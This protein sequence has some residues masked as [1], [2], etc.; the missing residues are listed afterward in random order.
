MET[1]WSS[2]G[3]RTNTQQSGPI[4]QD[5]DVSTLAPDRLGDILDA[6][7]RVI[8]R[9]GLD[10]LRAQAL[11]D[12]S[13]ASVAT[14]YHYVG[15]LD[16][17]VGALCA[18]ELGL[19]QVRRDVAQQTARGEIDDRL[20]AILAADLD[21]VVWRTRL[22]FLRRAIFDARVRD[23]VRAGEETAAAQLAR[24]VPERADDALRL[25]ALACGLG[26]LLV[27]GMIDPAEA[28]ALIEAA[29]AERPTWRPAT[30]RAEPALAESF[31]PRTAADPKERILDATIAQIAAHGAHGVRFPAVAEAA[32]VSQSLPRY[33]F[34]T[35]RELLDAAFARDT[36][37]AAARMR[38]GA[39][40]ADPLERLSHVYI[41]RS[42]AFLAALR[43]TLI[44]WSEYL[45]IATREPQAGDVARTRLEVWADYGVALGSELATIGQAQAERITRARSLSQVAINTGAAMLW[46]VGALDDRAYPA[47]VNATIDDTLGRP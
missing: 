14:P 23:L 40:S 36:A 38:H 31:P 21:P 34:P 8:E 30:A 27:L 2:A 19:A 45:S 20:R 24:I 1:Q 25:R 3:F 47:V 22:E 18:R 42:P 29:V 17:I 7:L 44:L 11:A 32:G 43:P 33:Y 37:L 46:L 28:E 10:G 4:R 15:S 5:A 12:E 35:R 26:V 41:G 6:A 13:G 16:D 39:S 9:D